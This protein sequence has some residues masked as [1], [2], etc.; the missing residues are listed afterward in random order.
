MIFNIFLTNIDEFE[1][2]SIINKYR[3]DNAAGYDLIM[4]KI[5]KSIFVL[6]SKHLALIPKLGILKIHDIT[7]QSPF[8]V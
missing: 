5:I 2:P 8:K 1:V 6:V 3:D 7:V 4:L